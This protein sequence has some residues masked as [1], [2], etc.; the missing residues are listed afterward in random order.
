M[1]F[2]LNKSFYACEG[3]FAWDLEKLNDLLKLGAV[4]HFFIEEETMVGFP[5]ELPL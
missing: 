1:L 4:E 5:T 3:Q 2:K